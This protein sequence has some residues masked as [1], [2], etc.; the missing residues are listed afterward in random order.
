MRARI[1]SPVRPT[2]NMPIVLPASGTRSV[3]GGV[4]KNG[5]IAKEAWQTIA[6][7]AQTRRDFFIEWIYALD[8]F[9]NLRARIASPVRPTANMPIVLPASGTPLG[10]VG[11]AK[12]GLM[13]K[14]DWQSIARNAQTKRDFFI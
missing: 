4:A 7:N 12:R 9:L 2:A 10:F 11:V 13:A 1:A 14:E 3:V 8:Y 5:L 6:R